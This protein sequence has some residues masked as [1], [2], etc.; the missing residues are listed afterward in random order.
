M[1]V[2]DSRAIKEFREGISAKIAAFWFWK[3]KFFCKKIL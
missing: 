1:H 3:K 2:S